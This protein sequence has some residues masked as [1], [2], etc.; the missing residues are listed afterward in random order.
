[1]KASRPAKAVQPRRTL[2]QLAG[3]RETGALH[4]EG[5]PGGTVY[6][7]AGWVSYVDSPAAPG[8]GDLLTASGRVPAPVW[9]A[10]TANGRDVGAQLVAAG[11]LTQ[12]ELELCV[13]G[14]IYDA[15]FFVLNPAPAKV[16][17]EP[18]ETHWL[19]PVCQVDAAVLGRE[20]TR[21]RRLLDEAHPQSDVDA[22][23]V[24]TIS[25]A[26]APRLVLTAPQWELIV[27]CDGQRTAADLARLLGRAAYTTVLELRRLAAA[28]LVSANGHAE[29]PASPPERKPAAASR[30]TVPATSSRPMQAEARLP[31]RTPAVPAGPPPVEAGL[32][33]PDESTL[34]RIRSG[35]EAL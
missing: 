22:D 18:G 29:P 12:G 35:L 1:M 8:V 34:T 24:R 3:A 6:L 16:R 20:L 32:D 26:P 9:Q 13:L 5:E 15:A 17:F 21:R 14:A 27:H 30:R 25:R 19:G 23:P 31:R 11:H 4:V 10:A 2:T 7:T 28:G 33:G